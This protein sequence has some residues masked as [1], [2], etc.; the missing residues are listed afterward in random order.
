MKGLLLGAMLMALHVLGPFSVPAEDQ[1]ILEI[2]RVY[3]E[4]AEKIRLEKENEPV[5]GNTHLVSYKN[6]MPGTGYQN[7]SVAFFHDDDRDPAGHP[8]DIIQTLRRVTVDYNISAIRFHV[9]YLFDREGLLLFHYLKDE[10]PSGGE[11]RFYFN[12]GQLIRAK[13][14]PVVGRGNGSF[15]RYEA[16]ESFS[17]VILETAEEIKKRADLYKNFF[18]QLIQNQHID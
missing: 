13:V 14:N 1:R 5:G 11:R 2:R 10:S 18:S 4:I 9:E 17:E 12:G 15:A 8:A 6:I 3:G 7:R 16:S